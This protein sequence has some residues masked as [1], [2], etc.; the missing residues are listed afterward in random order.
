MREE[1]QLLLDE[2]DDKIEASSG[3]V[4]MSYQKMSATVIA[5]I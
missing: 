4:V 5:Q 2:I 1:K 3:F